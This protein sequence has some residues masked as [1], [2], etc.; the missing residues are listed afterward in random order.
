M[1]PDILRLVIRRHPHLDDDDA[2]DDDVV[3]VVMMMVV[4]LVV[5]VVNKH[6]F[7]Q[8]FRP[9]LILNLEI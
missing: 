3:M 4:M 5:V 8:V 6:T 9:T 1:V 2:G 7:R